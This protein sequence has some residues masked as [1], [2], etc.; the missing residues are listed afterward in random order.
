VTLLVGARSG[1][2]H[3]AATVTTT[4]EPRDVMRAVSRFGSALKTLSPERS[5]P[6]PRAHVPEVSLGD[7][8]D[9]PGA[10]D[11]RDGDPGRGPGG[12]R[13]PLHR[14]AAGVLPRGDRGPRRGAR[15]VTDEGFVHPL[16]GPPGF[17]TRVARALKRSFLL[18]CVVRTEGIYPVDLH[19]RERIVAATGL[20]VPALC[21]LP[22]AERLAR[23]HDPPWEAI[24]PVVPRWRLAA[25]VDPTPETLELLPYV[26]NG[27][28][29]VWTARDAPGESRHSVVVG[30]FLRRASADESLVR[31]GASEGFTR[32]SKWG[33]RGSV[34]SVVDGETDAVEEAWVGKS[35]PLGVN[36]VTAAGFR[37]RLQRNPAEGDIAIT[38]VCNDTQ[39]DDERDVVDEA[40]GTQEWLPFDVTVVHG[41]ERSELRALLAEDREFLHYIGHIDHGGFECA[42][43]KLDAATLDSVGVD[44]FF[45]NAC[46]SYEQGIALVEAGSIAGVVTHSDVVNDEATRIGGVVARPLDGGFP[47]R[48]ALTLAREESVMGQQ[49]S[50]VGDGS[51]AISQTESVTPN[52][53]L[54]ATD[55][56]GYEA[57]VFTFPVKG[58]GSLFRP[59]IGDNDQFYLVLSRHLTFEGCRTRRSRRS[60]RWR[61]CRS[62][63]TVATYPGAEKRTS[64]NCSE[65]RTLNGG[66]RARQR[67]PS[68]REHEE[69]GEQDAD[70]PGVLF[71]VARDRAVGHRS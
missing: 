58:M 23:Y 64:R 15:V 17:E 49:Y 11:P 47:M 22:P 70:H 28:A 13:R 71:E 48:T 67:A 20:A 18:D 69:R 45:L 54:V 66:S 12:P 36:K 7:R 37:H 25:R 62:E 57:E 2:E 32:G 29:T 41:A 40:Y 9:A 19:E 4:G 1:H 43:G 42:D 3:P 53:C 38:V 61:T 50:V 60:C 56:G 35:C 68:L 8:F 10:L 59:H 27:L 34:G 63:S 52:G 5:F 65:L 21:D 24:V 51:L 30:E 26:V 14:R 39:I 16:T 55:D 44:A 33:G 46:Q 31:G 6:T